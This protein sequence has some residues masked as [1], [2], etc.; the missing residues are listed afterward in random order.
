MVSIRLI[1]I[2]SASIIAI[3]IKGCGNVWNFFEHTFIRPRFTFTGYVVNNDWITI[4]TT[5]SIRPV[6][7]KHIASSTTAERI[8]HSSHKNSMS[9]LDNFW[10]SMSGEQ[11]LASFSSSLYGMIIR[12][13]EI[14][15]MYYADIAII[16]V[17]CNSWQHTKIYVPCP[18]QTAA[19]TLITHT[20]IYIR[21]SKYSYSSP[22][23]TS[24]NNMRI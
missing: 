20:H 10:C 19:S 22:L 1:R 14:I 7:N 3:T 6:R 12:S 18:C 2:S 11:F 13:T 9:Y 17:V 4:D 21:V 15:Q 8:I 16:I 24:K 23:L 5:D